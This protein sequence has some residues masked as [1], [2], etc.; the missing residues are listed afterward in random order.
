MTEAEVIEMLNLHAANAMNGFTIYISFTFGFLTVAYLAGA[1]LSRVQVAI[2]SSLYFLAAGTFFLTTITHAQSFEALV[3]KYPDF[4]YSIFWHVPWT[5][6]AT[7]VQAGGILAS[8]YFLYDSRKTKINNP[9][10]TEKT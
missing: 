6:L 5:V 4:I 1:K 7:I 8:L 10:Q 2:I 3:A 9:D